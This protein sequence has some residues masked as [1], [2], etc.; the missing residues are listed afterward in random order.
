[1]AQQHR[2]SSLWVWLSLLAFALLG[3]VTYHRRQLPFVNVNDLTATIAQ[4]VLSSPLRNASG[5]TTDELLEHDPY[6]ETDVRDEAE[7]LED[8]DTG[9][10]DQSCSG[11]GVLC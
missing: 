3:A 2:Q 8:D 10:Y 7:Q 9:Q 6:A 1:M 4:D 5:A 11:R